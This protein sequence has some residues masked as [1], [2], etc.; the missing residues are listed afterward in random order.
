MG[1]V[2]RARDERL[3]RD[4]AVK[5][6]PESVRADPVR[7]SG[8]K[9]EAR[10][11]AALNHPN[12]GQIYGFEEPG[13][14]GSPFLVLELVE[15]P[16]LADR[17]A[18]GQ[19]PVPEAIAIATQIAAALEAA[20]DAGIV[21]RDLKPANVKLRPDGTV[22][23]LD[24]GLAKA[25]QGEPAVVGSAS[26]LA[27]FTATGT[28]MGLIVGTAAYMPP[29][30]AKGRPVDR[31]ADV[32]ALGVMLY[33][34][35][36]GK[37]LFDGD[38]VSDVLAAVLTREPNWSDLPVGTPAPLRRLL[39][40]C[41][42]KEPRARL[43]S[44]A[45]VRLDL[46]DAI[47]A[48]PPAAPHARQ[49]WTR[50][51]TPLLI[52]LACGAA[53]L[54]ISHWWWTPATV[55]SKA[56]GLA[57]TA[58]TADPAVVSAFTYGFALSPDERTLVYTGRAADGVRR[59][60][61]RRL[62]EAAAEPLDGTD[63]AESP[64]WSPDSQDIAF[65]ADGALRRVPASGGVVRTV[66]D[67]RGAWPRGTWNAA[68]TI[69]F[70]TDNIQSSGIRRVDA[71]GGTPARLVIDGPA[72]DPE[73][74]PDN[75]HFLFVRH[76]PGPPHLMVGTIDGTPS[77]EI[78]T[79]EGTSGEAAVRFSSAGF[80][81]FNQGGA[82]SIQSFNATA[83]RVEGPVA[84]VGRR[85]GT[86][87][88]WFAVSVSGTTV[89]AL[90]P[91]TADSG[92]TPGDPITQLEWVDRQGRRLGQLGDAARYWTLALSPDGSVVAVNPGKD[93]WT[94]NAAT[95]VSNRVVQGVGALWFPNGRDLLYRDDTGLGE[96]QAGGGT[97]HHILTFTERVGV[98]TSMTADGRL[99]TLTERVGG[100][101]KSLD[102]AVLN[103][104]DHSVKP[105]IA[106]DADESQAAFSPD[107]RSVAYVSDKTGRS[108]V[109]VRSVTDEASVVRV[110][111]AGGGHPMWRRDAKEL[112]FV[113][114]A[115]D[116]MAV[117]MSA[118]ER[119]SRAGTPTRLFHM[120]M[121]DVIRDWFPPYAMTA[122][123]QRF[124]VAIPE[125]PEPLSWTTHV[126]AAL[127]PGRP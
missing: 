126:E 39:T 107:G 22:K 47:E 116:M 38:D 114:P 101:A 119:T 29:E 4:V 15:G 13:D 78:M 6:L 61:R 124:L 20:H 69:L 93:I 63:D 73:W 95:G 77:A 54:L 27:T 113:S 125:R 82:L 51:A 81:V 12:I 46:A 115:D 108:E 71:A 40:R 85:A 1:E 58:M 117:D 25:L 70:S 83:L 86:P 21:H 7:L 41:L 14:G 37:R 75:R 36:T 5:I 2:Y 62:S 99:V 34:M 52:A 80:L 94:I 102:I 122:D 59:L 11:L 35:L 110:S 88:G 121:N 123:G 56:P 92:A 106:T 91:D 105:L 49:R 90:N 66:T 19:V 89:A 55:A 100:G 44:M 32:W 104:A 127:G 28:T 53:G 45:A 87:R 8:F 30:Q 97:P 23:V 31:R 48:P 68:G 26:A 42:V 16:T 118:Y 43:D 33:E 3:N 65:F 112:V 74:L 111:L 103:V 76:L 72:S 120:V 60:W 79:L 50:Q 84:V 98:P 10:T 64:F 18:S 67:A 96:I 24:F 9:R 109:Y 17:I 57:V